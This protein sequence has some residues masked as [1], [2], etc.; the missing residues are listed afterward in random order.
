VVCCDHGVAAIINFHRADPAAGRRH[1]AAVEAAARRIEHRVVATYTLARSLDL[2]HLGEP[3]EA[4]ALLHTALA[5]DADGEDLLLDAVRLGVQVGDPEVV[6]AATARVEALAAGSDI[7][8]RQ[9]AVLLCRGL[10]DRDPSRLLRAAEQAQLAGRPLLRAQALEAGALVLA[11]GGDLG[12]AQ[13]A[14]NH[15]L[16][17]FSVLA[18]GWDVAR[19][20]ARLRAYGG[21]RSPRVAHRRARQGW[22]SLTPTEAK[23]AAMVAD[24]MSNPAIAGQLFL[25][26]RTVATHVSHILTKLQVHSRIDVAREAGRR[27]S[28]S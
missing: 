3:A 13:A 20:Q 10:L 27:Y 19:V 15:A 25:S 6:A 22:E 7:P 24:G 16:D 14:L 18:A 12:S 17:G 2:E 26:P 28:A 5:N 9:A 4:L 11:D 21:R 1:L 8:H 23:I